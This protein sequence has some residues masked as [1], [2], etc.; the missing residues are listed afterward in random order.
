MPGAVLTAGAVIEHR[1]SQELRGK[2]RAACI[3]RHQCRRRRETATG[4]FS[5]DADP[6]RIDSQFVR[7]AR[8]PC[9]RGQAIL[10]R[11]RERVLWREPVFDRGDGDAQRRRR[12][13]RTVLHRFRRSDDHPAAMDVEQ[14]GAVPRIGRGIVPVDFEYSSWA[15]NCLD[16]GRQR[17]LAEERKALGRSHPCCGQAFAREPGEGHQIDQRQDLRIDKVA[18]GHG[19]P[20]IFSP[21]SG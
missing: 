5:D 13:R 11:G 10:L 8:Q 12:A 20:C 1:V 15:G 2:R 18:S 4:A 17:W 7:A 16:L 3:A 9:Q 14:S 19:I 6:G 21:A